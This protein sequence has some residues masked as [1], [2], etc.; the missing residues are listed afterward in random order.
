LKLVIQLVLESETMT[1][2]EGSGTCLRTIPDTARARCAAAADFFLLSFYPISFRSSVFMV[3]TRFPVSS[4]L[5]D[6]IR[7]GDHLYSKGDYD[8]AM[9]QFVKTVGWV[10]PSYVIRKVRSIPLCL[11][12][13]LRLYTSL[14]SCRFI[15]RSAWLCMALA[16][17]SPYPILTHALVA[18]SSTLNEFT[19]S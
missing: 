11:S 16:H 10:Q 8:G 15:V 7:Y 6:I 12:L 4:P 19:T 18:S 13:S 2:V 17:S 14:P 1:V 3:L 9:N 5:L